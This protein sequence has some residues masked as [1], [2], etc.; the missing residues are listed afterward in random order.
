MWMLGGEK[1]KGKAEG[2]EAGKYLGREGTGGCGAAG[3]STHH[4]ANMDMYGE[5]RTACL[6]ARSEGQL[7]SGG[8]VTGT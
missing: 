1:R 8:P 6:P 5:E 7:D 2:K 3:M 4:D